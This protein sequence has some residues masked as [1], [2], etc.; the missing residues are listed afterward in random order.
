MRA[1]L[2]AEAKVKAHAARRRGIL[3]GA[4]GLVAMMGL[5]T[6]GLAWWQERQAAMVYD[7]P[8]EYYTPT[9]IEMAALQPKVD[10]PTAA[11]DAHP[12]KNTPKKDTPTVATTSG[13][14]SP[15]PTATPTATLS[16]AVASHPG[17]LTD[18]P[19]PTM[20][21]GAASS[22]ITGI[23]VKVN[24]GLAHILTDDDEI[25][26][27]AAS[28]AS[29]YKPQVDSCFRSALALAPDLKGLWTVT[30]TITPEGTTKSVEVQAAGAKVPN[31]EACVTHSVA[32]WRFQRIDHDFNVR[33]KFNY[34]GAD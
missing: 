26:Q 16:A 5:A 20:G 28:V 21:G 14:S 4:L 29:R 9:P 25:R 23:E 18:A 12:V 7:L 27:M 24:D 31:F 19:P 13:S 11:A 3:L 1:K 8:D 10:T 6:V 2:E 33:K 34:S 22:G 30:F 32:G 17:G 15:T